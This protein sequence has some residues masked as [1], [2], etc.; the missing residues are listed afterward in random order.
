M[1]KEEVVIVRQKSANTKK[2][3][4]LRIVVGWKPKERARFLELRVAN[5]TKSG[6]GHPKLRGSSSTHLYPSH[7]LHPVKARQGEWFVVNMKMKY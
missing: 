3:K 2:R 6:T 7:F 5:L 1:S 4:E